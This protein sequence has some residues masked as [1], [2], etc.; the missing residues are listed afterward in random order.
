MNIH[1]EDSDMKIV[2]SSKLT[3]EEGFDVIQLVEETKLQRFNGNSAKAKSL[4]ANIVSAFSYKA[5][6]E[7]LLQLAKEHD[8]EVT[9]EVLLQMKILTVFS[10]E[11]CIDNFLP[12]PMLSTVAV[13]E[14]YDVLEKVSPDF[15]E[16]LSKSTAFSFYY[17]CLKDDCK[18]EDV[19]IGEQ[20]ACACGRKGDSAYE[21]LGKDLHNINVIVFK[22]AI[23]AFA[24]V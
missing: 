6:P 9:Q 4:G 21:K 10:A 12:S 13:G 20:F 8:V 16:E 5:A 3:K 2:G 18:E 14:L 19:C 11:Y 23:Q 24:F 15:Y 1:N 17:L 7:E 22:K